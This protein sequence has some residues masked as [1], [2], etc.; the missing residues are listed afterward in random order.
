ME[1][2]FILII[3]FAVCAFIGWLV[4][5]PYAI[6]DKNKFENFGILTGPF[7]PIYGFVA[8]VAYFLS[9]ILFYIPLPAQLLIYFII[10]TLIEFNTSFFLEKFFRIKLWDYSNYRCNLK[11]RICLR[12]SVLWGIFLIMGVYFLQPIVITKVL[13]IPQLWI[14]GIAI[15][16]LIF[17][18]TD[19]IFSIKRLTKIIPKGVKLYIKNKVPLKDDSRKS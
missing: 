9:L 11:G 6:R 15:L 3:Y 18:I 12:L 13:T 19:F 10:P 2:I 1:S 7:V 5:Q 17:I 14:R 16:F 8:L 4:E